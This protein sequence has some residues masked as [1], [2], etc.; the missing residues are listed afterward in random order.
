GSLWSRTGTLLGQA[1]FA[2]ETASGWQ[3]VTFAVPVAIAANTTYVASYHM[4]AGHYAEDDGTF[5]SSGVDSGP[6]HGLKA[7]VDGADGV[8]AYSSAS[9]FPSSSYQSA[10]YW[11]DVVFS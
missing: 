8:Y 4:T 2:N 7:G 1:T 9:K 6:L 10:N 3:Q 5:A 11:V